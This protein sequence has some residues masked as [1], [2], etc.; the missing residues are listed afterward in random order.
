MRLLASALLLALTAC[1]SE[2]PTVNEP[3]ANQPRA[4]AGCA[5]HLA[6]HVDRGSFAAAAI[7]ANAAQV[8]RWGKQSAD[9]FKTAAAELCGEG[10]LNS[11]G[12]SPLKRLSVQYAAGADNASVWQDEDRPGV[13]ILEY[14]FTPGTP[15]PDEADVRD[16]IRCWAK[17]EEALCSPR[18]P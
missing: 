11:A 17:W 15:P 6:L 13:V 1:G 18:L 7:N 4:D 9:T 12:L 8:D 3:A 2:G 5:D 14:A 16:A 10:W